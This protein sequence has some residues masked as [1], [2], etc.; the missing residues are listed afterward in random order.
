M[1]NVAVSYVDGRFSGPEEKPDSFYY[2]FL[3][4]HK[5]GY[6]GRNLIRELIPDDFAPPPKGIKI[7]G[8]LEGAISINVY[9]HS[10]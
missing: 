7:F 2:R 4:L 3:D 10:Q 1:M 6:T 8:V 9:I 5:A